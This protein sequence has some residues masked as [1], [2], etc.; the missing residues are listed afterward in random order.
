MT[1]FCIYFINC[2]RIKNPFTWVFEIE[3]IY[4]RMAEYKAKKESSPWEYAQIGMV[5]AFLV[6]L[7][8][9][10][11]YGLDRKFDTSPW[12]MLV[13]SFLGFLSGIYVSLKDF[14]FK[15]K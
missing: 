15:T 11:G 8:F 12:L 14:I 10:V 13:G 2:Q 3:I 6:L 9:L 4:D 5:L 7:G 1:S